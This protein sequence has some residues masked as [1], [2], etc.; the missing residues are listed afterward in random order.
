MSIREDC[1]VLTVLYYPV[2][3]MLTLY[4]TVMYITV[5]VPCHTVLY[6]TVLYCTVLYCTVLYC[7]VLYC[8][9]LYCTVLYCTVLYCTVQAIPECVYSTVPVQYRLHV[10]SFKTF[11]FRFDIHWY[12]TFG[13]NLDHPLEHYISE[14]IPIIRPNVSDS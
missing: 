5:L 3:P 2:C 13:H 12:H 7:T 10:R 14:L 11:M 1:T 8:T 6:C 4:C 9:V